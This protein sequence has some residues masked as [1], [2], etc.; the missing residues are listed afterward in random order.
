MGGWGNNDQP[1]WKDVMSQSG[2]DDMTLLSKLTN[3]QIMQNLKE[4]FENGIIYTNIGD[5]L[6]SV[7]P[8][9]WLQI[10]GSEIIQSYVGKARIELPPHIYGV[11]E[12]AY[13]AM[14]LDKENQCILITGESGAGK[15]EAAKKVMEYISE[16]CSSEDEGSAK[17]LNHVKNIILETNPLLE[18]FGNAKTLRNNNSSR[19]G[20]Y[21]EIHFTQGG[22]PVGGNIINYLLEKSRV[23]MQLDG[24]RNFHVFYQF[25]VGASAEEQQDYGLHGPEA[26]DYLCKGNC[27]SVPGI[28]DV[29]EYKE[30][31]H[32]M[33]VIG[34]T[35][36]EQSDIMRLLGSILWMGNVD[37]AEANE[38]AEVS[39]M[40]VLEFVASLLG[41]PAPFVKTAFEIREM[42]TKHGMA[43]GTTYKVPLN[44]VQACATRDALAKGIYGTL[45]DWLVQTVNRAMVFKEKNT[46]SIGVLDIYGFEV[47]KK[48]VFE[49]FCINYVNEKLQQFFIELTLKAEQ[50]EYASEGIKWEPI[51][52]FNNQIVCEL[53]DGKRPPGIFSVLD[54]VCFTIHATSKGTDVKFLGKAGGA[55]SSHLHFRPFDTAF[56][57]KHYAGEVTYDVEGFC[58]KN[59][60]TLFNDL[61]ETMQCSTNDFLVKLFPEDT[62]DTSSRKRPTTAGFKIK[63]SA[64]KLMQTLAQCTPHY[65]RCIK[66]NET[67]R[68]LDWDHPRVK[69][70]VQY[71][72]LLENVR[73]RRAGF[74]YRA[75]FARFLKRYQKLSR[76]TW[77]MRGKWQGSAIDGCTTL[78]QDLQLEQGQWQMGKTKVFIR[79]PETL[80]HLE[81]LLERHD[82]DCTVK[83]QRAW[84]KW[85]ARKHALEQRAAAADKLRGKKE[86][87]QSSMSRQYDADYIR[88]EDNYPLQNV[89]TQGE[90]MVFADQVVKLNRRSK[91]E[92][93]DLVITTTAIYMVMRKKKKGEVVYSMT[94]RTPITNLGSIS[95]STLSDNYIV[96][97]VPSEYDNLFENEKKTEIAT[98]LCE[99]YENS[100]GRELPINF[101]DAISYKIKTKDTRN[102]RFQKNEAAATAM[103]KKAGKNLTV[104]IKTGLP[105]DTDTTPK[106]FANR[107]ASASRSGPVSGG[108][109]GGGGG[110]GGGR[111]GGGGGGYGAS[112]GAS[113]AAS[114]GGRGGGASRGGGGGGGGAARGGM[115]GIA[116]A[117]GGRGG[118]GGGSRGRG[119]PAGRGRGRGAG[120]PQPRRPQA[121]ALYPY[122]AA[123]D[124]ELTFSE[125]DIIFIVQKDQAGWWEGEL[126][127][128]KG[129]VP[130][131]YVQ[132][133]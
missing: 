54:D 83:I 28:D 105:K 69:H 53:M 111:G 72:G 84:K 16:V 49:Q 7:N 64:Q 95:L 1:A 126:N 109:Y 40:S 110:G 65:V 123:T 113:S 56:S 98:V 43:R 11:A 12:Q 94:R 118:R 21:F 37:F 89:I 61:I 74:A 119:G 60:D 6:I 102:V 10:F 62:K 112:T 48:N 41:V 66:P 2:L 120:P 22:M 17:R 32:A 79:H 75:E 106:N 122:E 131:N 90:E 128:K 77:S 23:I 18:A 101:T 85:K 8:Y 5:V 44:Y 82:Y 29:K 108:A 68:P 3:E 132:E 13:R 96:I 59:K 103:L 88:Y 70:Q 125:G 27:L 35:A 100:T 50:E 30:M 124:D 115:G 14:V 127:G 121:K 24:E 86:R 116:A 76:K 47:F 25:C 51:K 9:Q 63:T 117:I 39:D 107:G 104:S 42:E 129:W 36:K 93:R 58:D 57:I 34:I 26:F 4:R 71:L 20:K 15:T 31:R 78:L 33:N 130:A 73:V 80:F 81:E 114:R 99:A 45:F 38:R 133:I 87:Q 97:H 55:F 19:F 91:P 46:L 92:R 67:K 52:Y